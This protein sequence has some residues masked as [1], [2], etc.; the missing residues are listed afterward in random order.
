MAIL[1]QLRS[2]LKEEERNYGRVRRERESELKRI[3]ERKKG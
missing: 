2:N 1:P 3:R